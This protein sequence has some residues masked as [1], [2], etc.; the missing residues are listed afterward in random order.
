MENLVLYIHGKGGNSLEAEHYKN[1]FSYYDVK[2]LDY[3]SNTP[4]DFIEEVNHIINKIVEQYGNAIIVANSIGAY[5]A[6]NALSKMKI[7]K[8]F[9]YFSNC[10]YGKGY[11]EYDDISKC[12]RAVIKRKANN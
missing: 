9:F 5:F 11:F 1:L 8:A 4:W 6:M 10:R 7:K 12:F 3:K 2:G